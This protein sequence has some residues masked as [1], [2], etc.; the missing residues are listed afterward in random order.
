M[1][2][3]LCRHHGPPM[4]QLRQ[5]SSHGSYKTHQA[6]VPEPGGGV[7]GGVGGRGGLSEKIRWPVEAKISVPTPQHIT[8]TQLSHSQEAS[9]LR[10]LFGQPCDSVGR[11]ANSQPQ[12]EADPGTGREEGDQGRAGRLVYVCGGQGEPVQPGEGDSLAFE[13][14][15]EGGNLHQ[16]LHT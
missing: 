8:S 13:S 4:K 2:L 12:R 9:D 6:P 7:G 3:L 14:G 15:F 1:L 10:Q 5:L 11:A 16:A